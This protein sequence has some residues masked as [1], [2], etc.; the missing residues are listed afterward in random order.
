M[1]VASRD[2]KSPLIILASGQS[3]TEAQSEEAFSIIMS[4]DATPA[5]I[6]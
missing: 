3:L 5:Q 6:G 2:L 1:T 4:G